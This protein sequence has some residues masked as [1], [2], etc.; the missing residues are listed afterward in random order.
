MIRSADSQFPF[1]GLVCYLHDL[2]GGNIHTKGVVN[3]VCLSIGR[4]QCWK[5]VDYDW[6]DY[7]HSNHVA[8]SWIQFGF[9]NR[10]VSIS[11]YSLKSHNGSSSEFLHWTLSGSTDGNSWI[12]LDRRNTEDLKGRSITKTLEC[13]ERPSVC[14]FYRYVRL[15]Q[16]GKNSNN[17]DYFILTNIEFFGSMVNFMSHDWVIPQPILS[18]S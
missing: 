2:C 10:S 9:K 5:V 18:N 7:W 8:S 4:N 12:V 16:T 6:N 11:H 1:S 13:N 17:N 14:K 3:I 15:T